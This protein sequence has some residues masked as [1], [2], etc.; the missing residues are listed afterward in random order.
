MGHEFLWPGMIGT[1]WQ[2]WNRRSIGPAVLPGKVLRRAYR[3][4]CIL[5]APCVPHVMFFL[6]AP[7]VPHVAVP[8]AGI[9]SDIWQ[10]GTAN[11]QM[12]QISPE[13]SGVARSAYKHAPQALI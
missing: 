8:P 9:F 2:G 13:R 11:F 10:T 1:V 3:T 6:V 5:I 7:C 4:P 12:Y